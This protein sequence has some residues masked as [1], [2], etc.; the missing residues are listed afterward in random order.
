MGE[1]GEK[2]REGV[3]REFKGRHRTCLKQRRHEGSAGEQE[4]GKA[5]ELT[6]RASGNLG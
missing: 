4:K 2:E 5:R 3:P 1:D 6:T